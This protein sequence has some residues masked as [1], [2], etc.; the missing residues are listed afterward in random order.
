MKPFLQAKTAGLP[1]WAW[2]TLLA[3]GIGFGL[4]MRHRSSSEPEVEEAMEEQGFEVPEN[5]HEEYGGTE[6][7]GGLQ[8]LGVPG[9][10][11]GGLTPIQTPYVP[12]SLP[13]IITSQGETV[14][15]LANGVI[16][17]QN[18]TTQLAT[19]ILEREP[20][21]EI[22]REKIGGP[23]KRQPVH[24][25]PKQRKPPPKKKPVAKKPKKPVKKK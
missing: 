20:P 15:A 3:G 22:I 2:L 18:A 21:K 7:A 23:A 10:V 5:I 12:E 4:Y 14:G 19:A 25:P 8:A 24:K 13:E 1:R 16:E 11:S 6:S 17:N 9:P